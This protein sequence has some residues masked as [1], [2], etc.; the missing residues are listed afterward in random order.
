MT[1][2]R[3]WTTAER[4]IMKT[5]E[6]TYRNRKRSENNNNF[7]FAFKSDSTFF[8]KT[9]LQDGRGLMRCRW[10]LTRGPCG[11]PFLFKF[12]SKVFDGLPPDCTHPSFPFWTVRTEMGL[13]KTVSFIH[14]FIV[15][16]GSILLVH[17]DTMQIETY[18]PIL[19]SMLYCQFCPLMLKFFFFFLK[20]QCSPYR[21]DVNKGIQIL[22][23]F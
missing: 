21:R 17:D 9:F 19:L 7:S 1:L 23:S 18:D 6:Y 12:I 14:A 15:L 16:P 8:V 11:S 2:M 13:S 10:D 3:W 20:L 22:F 5:M 4:I